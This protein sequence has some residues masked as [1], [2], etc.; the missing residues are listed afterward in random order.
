MRLQWLA[1]PGALLVAVGM[2]TY[3]AQ[4]SDIDPETREFVESVI[5]RA[6]VQDL[7][8]DLEFFG[9]GERPNPGHIDQTLSPSDA[10]TLRDL[11]S[12]ALEIA[13]AVQDWAQ[14]P[15]FYGGQRAVAGYSDVS[16]QLVGMGKQDIH[17]TPR[18]QY[19]LIGQ[20]RRAF[21]YAAQYPWRLMVQIDGPDEHD[22][23]VTKE[24]KP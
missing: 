6:S 14:R 16:F 18:G 3:Y 24:F 8:P 5:D 13:R 9:E 20:E 19:E 12:E 1:L 11:E 7:L 23:L 22:L 21:V 2:P 17:R 15:A 4:N 10:R